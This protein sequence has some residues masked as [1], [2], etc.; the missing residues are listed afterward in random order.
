M[1]LSKETSSAYSKNSYEPDSLIRCN[2]YC[3]V[4]LKPCHSH[5]ARSTTPPNP[6][7]QASI[8]HSII[9]HQPIVLNPTLAQ[10][11]Y[12]AYWGPIGG[13]GSPPV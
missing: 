4:P 7:S 9:P 3:P 1:K 8:S 2:P 13:G 5:C 10:V 11:D 12:L 6:H